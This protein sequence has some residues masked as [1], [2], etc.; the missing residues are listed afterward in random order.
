MKEFL[1]ARVQVATGNASD[2]FLFVGD[3]NTGIGPADGPMK[4]LR[5]CGS[6]HRSQAAAFKDAWRR[7]DGDRIEHTYTSPRIG[8]S[9][10]RI[11][12]AL[13]SPALL[14]RFTVSAVR[15]RNGRAGLQTIQ[16]WWSRY[17]I[18]IDRGRMHDATTG[19]S[20]NSVVAANTLLNC[21]GPEH[22]GGPAGS[23]LSSQRRYSALVRNRSAMLPE[24][25]PK[26]MPSE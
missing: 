1:N 12:H 25:C 16:C 13:A 20:G 26:T 4:Q 23:P 9:S 2:P 3:F 7:H 22:Y 17:R 21:R 10:Y 19:N 5:Q 14:P 15:T 8:T 24:R 18:F 11:D 6:F